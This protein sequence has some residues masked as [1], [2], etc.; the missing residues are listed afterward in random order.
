MV[1]WARQGVP[2]GRRGGTDHSQWHSSRTILGHH[3]VQL[4]HQS[5]RRQTPSDVRG[6]QE[7]SLARECLPVGL[8]NV[9]FAAGNLERGFDRPKRIS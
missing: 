7:Q 4:S 3:G 8:A 9:S 5:R 2:P 6:R 1:A